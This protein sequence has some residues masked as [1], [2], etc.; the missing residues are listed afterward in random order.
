M[1]WAPDY[2]N[3]A[4]LTNYIRVGDT[5]DDSE[6]ELAASAASRAVDLCTGRQF[7]L[8]DAPEQRFYPVTWSRARQRWVAVIDDLQTTTGLSGVSGYTLLPR[9]ALQMGKP[10]EAM[11]FATDPRDDNG[12]IG[13]T[14]RWGWTTT[15]QAVKLASRLQASRFVARRDSPY[16]VAGSPQQGS[17]LRLLARVDP[18]V[19]VSL[20][21]YVRDWW[22]A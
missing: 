1:A 9:N 11:E 22:A 3:V 8:V 21:H 20:R 5:L 4:E 7:G 15:P 17:E 12:E 13:P 18:D 19:A 10:W 16:G 14:A 6:L 2:V